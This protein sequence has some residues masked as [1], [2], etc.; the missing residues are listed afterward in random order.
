MA[1]EN[2]ES[3]KMNATS[4]GTTRIDSLECELLLLDDPPNARPSRPLTSILGAPF[5]GGIGGRGI[6]SG[7]MA[8]GSV[9][10]SMEQSMDVSEGKV[11]AKV[12][13]TLDLRASFLHYCA[14]SMRPT[15][16]QLAAEGPFMSAQQFTTMAKEMGLVEPEG[17]NCEV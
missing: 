13:D 4:T 16:M 11:T 14:S 2:L 8:A 6:G 9:P 5:Q 3:H 1:V 17:G 12:H 10:Q 15:E 7:V